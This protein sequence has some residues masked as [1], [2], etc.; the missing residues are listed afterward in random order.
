MCEEHSTYDIPYAT[1]VLL[2]DIANY[3][4]KQEY[5]NRCHSCKYN[6]KVYHNKLDRVV[7]YC[8]YNEHRTTPHNCCG[9]Y[10]SR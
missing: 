5:V 4:K 2:K 3:L 7:D 9:Y 8:F 6:Q 10:E 1:Q